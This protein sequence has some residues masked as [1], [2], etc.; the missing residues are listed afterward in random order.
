MQKFILIANGARLEFPSAD[1]IATHLRDDIADVEEG[2]LSELNY[3]IT[4]ER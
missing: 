2:R 4:I 3:T 1:D